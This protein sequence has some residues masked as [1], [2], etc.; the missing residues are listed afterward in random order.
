MSLPRVLLAEQSLPYRR[1]LREALTAFRECEVDDTP[2]PEAAFDM[3][4]RRDYALFLFALDLPRLPGDLLDR[5]LASAYPR[6]HPGVHAAPPVIYLI[7][8][9]EL[10]RM[11]SLARVSRVRGHV[12]IPPR[13]DSLLQLT[14]HLLPSRPGASDLGAAPFPP[15]A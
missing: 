4:L 12:L 15:P 7:R 11:P 14:Q 2:D 8:P 13:L 10:P 3:A 1:V 5:L 9:S 6:C